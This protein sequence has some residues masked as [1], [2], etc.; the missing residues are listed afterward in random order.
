MDEAKVLMES[1]I[2]DYFGWNAA[3]LERHE[4]SSH[5]DAGLFAAVQYSKKEYADLIGR[6]CRPGFVAQPISY[7]I[8][9]QHNPEVEV[10]VSI[11]PRGDRCLVKTRLT[12]LNER[13]QDFEYRLSRS[14]ERW[15]LESVKCVVSGRRYDLL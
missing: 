7:G 13:D 8:P 11:R 14:N 15:F 4:R 1:F 9:P 3:A 5:S 10:I 2:A 6:Y 12:E